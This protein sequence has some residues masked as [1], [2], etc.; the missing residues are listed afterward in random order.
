MLRTDQNKQFE[1]NQGLEFKTG[2]KGIL[3]FFLLNKCLINILLKKLNLKRFSFQR[4]NTSDQLLFISFFTRILFLE[5]K[6]LYLAKKLQ[7]KSFSY[8]IAASK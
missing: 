3:V 7:Q 6:Y 2:S 5:L 4:K 1:N 8:Q